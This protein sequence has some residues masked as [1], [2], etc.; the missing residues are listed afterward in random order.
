[1]LQ[2]CVLPPG[3]DTCSSRYMNQPQPVSFFLSQLI[4]IILFGHI[5]FCSLSFPLTFILYVSICHTPSSFTSF[6]PHPVS[7]DLPVAP[8]SPSGRDKG[9]LPSPVFF[10][11]L[12]YLPSL[13]H[14]AVHP[15][16]PLAS[17][18]S[19]SSPD[20]YPL[21]HWSVRGFALKI[22]AFWDTALCRL[23]VD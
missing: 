22:T 17:L 12:G 18:L 2:R 11:C 14:A 9:L 15:L 5:P 7:G 21:L 23:E 8:T 10:A 6:Y 20:P 3:Q 19:L 1:M 16:L 4:V 13:C